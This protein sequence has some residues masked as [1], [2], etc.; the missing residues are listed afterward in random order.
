MEGAGMFNLAGN[1]QGDASM[2][3]AVHTRRI[4]DPI[5]GAKVT[6]S[7]GGVSFSSLTAIDQA[8][9]RVEDPLDP[10]A[11]EDK[12]WQIARGQVSLAPGSYAGMLGTFTSFAGRDNG[13]VS[14]DLNLRVSRSQRV[15]AFVVGTATRGGGEPAREDVGTQVTY[16]YSSQRVNTQWQVEHYGRD[17]VMDTA[18]INRVG[19]TSG[20]GYVDYNFYPDKTKH[21]WIRRISPFTFVQVGRDRIQG[22]DEYVSV[23]GGRFS[24]SR[25]G[26]VR[27]DKIFGKEA[28]QG[29][30]YDTDRWR[31]NAQAQ[32]YRW[33]RPY[34][35]YNVGG[36]VYYDDLAPFQG[37]SKNLTF[38]GTLQPNGRLT[39]NIE[40]NRVA[41]DRR[42]T[43]ERVYTVTLLDT[44][45]TYQFTK[46]LAA[47]AIVQ[48]DSQRS[49]VLTDF[50]GSY[51]PRPGTVVYIGYGALYERRVWDIDHWLAQ[52]G[53]YLSSRRGVF[54]KASYLY[55]F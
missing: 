33:L 23:T 9:G 3:Y 55:R 16:G 4:V 32:L 52:Q 21:P 35:S 34:G 11:G 39:S 28:W 6:G 53:D 26:F 5:F 25:Q 10:A 15:T 17:F 37:R 7:A 31:F 45:T 2:L 44:R 43:G 22:A 20:W 49:S 38:G 40:Y 48:Y 50:L 18:F 8:P 24:F 30:Q 36:A 42:S 1:A 29:Q 12:L 13:T 51:E 27:V 41:F 14:A 46:A 19:L 54:L 47:R